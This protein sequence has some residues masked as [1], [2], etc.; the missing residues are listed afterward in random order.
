MRNCKPA[1][2]AA[3]CW[4]LAAWCC[5]DCRANN[6]TTSEATAPAN[7]GKPHLTSPPAAMTAIC[8]NRWVLHEEHESAIPFFLGANTC[9]EKHLESRAHQHA[10]EGCKIVTTDHA[11][12]LFEMQQRLVPQGRPGP[13]L[14]CSVSQGSVSPPPPTTLTLTL[15]HPQATPPSRCSLH[16][17]H[18]QLFTCP[19]AQR[20]MGARC[21]NNRGASQ[22]FELPNA[23]KKRPGNL[24]PPKKIRAVASAAAYCP[25]QTSVTWTAATAI[26]SEIRGYGQ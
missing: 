23:K 17:G 14:A 5:F 18:D 19:D 6:N 11:S 10:I 26:E 1:V 25:P 4:L 24:T 12:T 15:S 8:S 13:S 22:K 16:E 7:T 9:V 2:R 3:C 20:P 21:P